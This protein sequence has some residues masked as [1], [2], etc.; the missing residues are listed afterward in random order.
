MFHSKEDTQ[1]VRENI[2]PVLDNGE[3]QGGHGQRYAGRFSLYFGERDGHCGKSEVANIDDNLEACRAA[4]VV[5]TPN[6]VKDPLCD[7]VLHLIIQQQYEGQI[8]KIN[9]IKVSGILAE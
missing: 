6:L 4:L 7:P 9:V 5:L 1:W 2:L 8:S 3:I